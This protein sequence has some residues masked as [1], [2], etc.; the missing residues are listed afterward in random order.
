[1][2]SYFSTLT[3]IFNNNDLE[4]KDKYSKK[5]S[6]KPIKTLIFSP[7]NLF[8]GWSDRLKMIFGFPLYYFYYELKINSQEKL[9]LKDFMLKWLKQIKAYMISALFIR[10][11]K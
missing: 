7:K 10:M 4:L 5:A 8:K 1:M 6:K 2:E 9:K 11:V 3:V